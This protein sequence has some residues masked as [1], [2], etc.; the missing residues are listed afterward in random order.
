MM[1]MTGRVRPF[2]THAHIS[3]G[4]DTGFLQQFASVFSQCMLTV[5]RYETFPTYET[6][7]YTGV[8]CRYLIHCDFLSRYVSLFG[9]DRC[10]RECKFNVDVLGCV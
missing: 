10:I 5:E 7:V 8:R 9:Y 3:R 1:M 6:T 2:T 4:N